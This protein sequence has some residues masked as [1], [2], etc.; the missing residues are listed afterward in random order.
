MTETTIF[1]ICLAGVISIALALFM[2]GYR[3]NYNRSLRWIFGI[4]RTLT[5][6]AVLLL[7]IN[8][9]FKS[10]SYTVV[11]PKLPV[12]VD[13]SS[14]VNELSQSQEVL[15]LIKKLQNNEALNEKFDV[16]F[17]KFGNDFAEMDSLQFSEKNTNIYEALSATDQLFND[18]VAPMLLISDGNQTLGN[19]Y[20]FISRTIKNPVYPI[21]I[22]DSI[23]YTDL[24]IEQLN[25][26]RYAFLKNQFPVEVILVYQ[27]DASVTSE[28]VVKQG[29]A[30]VYRKNISFS[31]VDNTEIVSFTLPA[32]SV[33]LQKYSAEIKAIADEKNTVNNSKQFAVEVIDQATQVLV[34]SNILHPDLGALNKSITSN[35]QRRFEVKKPSE[36]LAALQEAQLI[37]LYQPDRSF[38]NVFS[39]IKK[40][41]KNT[42]IISGL[43]TDWNFLNNK[44]EYF[45]K[46]TGRQ[47][48]D[49]TAAL[50]TNYSTFSV[51][52]IGFNDFRPL[53]TT[54]GTLLVDVPHEVLL[55]HTI[56][57]FETDSPLLATVEYNGQRS[58]IW[59]GEGLWKW[60]A[61]TYLNTNSFEAFDTFIGKL[62][63]Y[64][65]SNK[66]RSRLEVAHETFYYN[67]NEIQLS[68]QYFDQNF[69]FDPRAS[70]VIKVINTETEE[71]TVFPLLLKNNFYVVDLNSLE[72]GT[73][74]FTVY[75]EGEAISRSGNFS[76][77]DFNVEQQ[78]LNP[79]IKKLQSVALATN[80][81]AA[82]IT[83]YEAI[84]K[85]LL[86][87]DVYPSIQK[88]EQKVVPLVDWQY[89]LIFITLSLTL[90][91]FIRKYNGL[92]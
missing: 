59:D 41:N 12:L 88:N 47:A 51:E 5:I 92:I 81:K 46:E 64:L 58:A 72:S 62:L 55:K 38:E 86:A 24:K 10:D 14:S 35:E 60:R 40:L 16:S 70:L 91:W 63:Q 39:E 57:G 61:Q 20:E 17:F 26:N 6:F 73:Y 48:E 28:F 43:Q 80:G 19:D 74:T 15:D 21:I 50:Q 34:I 45:K 87:E 52:D 25:A 69:V 9:K 13:N 23:Q 77:L 67:N 83:D 66:R 71:E 11:K 2:Y 31:E 1:Y 32:S 37:V 54:F 30:V 49:V 33:G 44:Q 3:S 56:N 68:A 18:E 90:E 65:A 53:K 79:N 29:T 42:W 89:L 84:L 82:F 8:P 22:G 4:L 76:I 85:D 75:V 7:L 27:G 78:F 36:S